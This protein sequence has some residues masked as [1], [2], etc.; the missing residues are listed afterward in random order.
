MGKTKKSTA[1]SA[2]LTVNLSSSSL[3][4]DLGGE[5]VVTMAAVKNLLAVQESMLRSFF[6]TVINGINTRVALDI[7]LFAEDTSLFFSHRDLISLGLT[8]NSELVKLTDC[9]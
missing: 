3:E 5:E 9:K 6:D 4:E 1:K 7:L 2:K 8:V